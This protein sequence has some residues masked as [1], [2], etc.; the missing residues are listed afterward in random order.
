MDGIADDGLVGAV[1]PVPDSIVTFSRQTSASPPFD[2]DVRKRPRTF[3][4]TRLLPFETESESDRLVHLDH[5]IENIYIAC[6]ANSLS[7]G[8]LLHWTRELRSWLQLKFDMPVST[9]TRL[10]AIYYE[11]ALAQGMTLSASEKF[12]TMFVHL[13]Q[14]RAFVD[15]SQLTLDWRLLFR[16]L[17]RI[18]FPNHW[19]SAIRHHEKDFESLTKMGFIARRFFTPESTLEILEEVLPFYNT[20]R[21]NTAH[22]VVALLD[23]LLPTDVVPEGYSHVY[24]QKWLPSLFHIWELYTRSQHYDLIMMD[25][26]SRLAQGSLHVGHIPFSSTGIFTKEQTALMFT[27]ALR[28]I[29]V[30]V[31]RAGSPYLGAFE[32]HLAVS[33]SDHKRSRSARPIARW[34]ISSLSPDSIIDPDSTLRGLQGLIQCVETFFHP[35]NSGSWTKQ[36]TQLV[37]SLTDFFVLRWNREQSGELDVPPERRLTAE[38]RREFVLTLK[39]VVFM[40]IHSKSSSGAMNSQAALQC[41]AMLEPDI[42]LPTAL[43]QSYPSLQGLVETHRTITSLRT[44]T[45]LSQTVI[46]HKPSRMHVTALLGLALPGIDANDLTKT[47]QSLAFIQSI[48]SYVP[49]ADLSEGIG[50]GLAMEYITNAID[51][52]E[53]DGENAVIQLTDEDE[54]TV[55]KS[56]TATFGEFITSF[57]GRIFSLLENLPDAV[58]SR[59]RAAPEQNAVNMLPAAFSV[60]LGALSD[61]LFDLVLDKYTDFITDHVIPQA[62][63]A[64]ANLMSCLAKAQPERT[65]AKLFKVLEGNIREEI[66]ENHAGTAK[67]LET[68]PKDR[69]LVWYLSMFRKAVW[70]AGDV[71]LKYRTEIVDLIQFLRERCRGAASVHTSNL[72]HH[73]IYALTNV[74]TSD[75]KLLNDSDFK[76]RGYNI[77]DWGRQVDPTDGL[78]VKWHVPDQEQI[79]FAVEVF[80]RHVEL[81]IAELQKLMSEG[82]KAHKDWS[83]EV[84][85][86]LN[87]LRLLISG[88]AVLYDPKK[89]AT[90]EPP[91]KAIESNGD[92]EMKDAEGEEYE[93]MVGRSESFVNGADE[94]GLPLDDDM[95]SDEDDVDGEDGNGDGDGDEESNPIKKLFTYPVGYYFKDT[96]D[97]LYV[98]VHDLHERIGWVLHEVHDYLHAN[99]EDDVHSLKTL[100]SVCRVWFIDVGSER[101]LKLLDTYIRSYL[102]D[103]R[104]YKISG[105]RKC[106]PRYLLTKRAFIYHLQRIKHNNGIRDMSPLDKILLQDLMYDSL[107]RYADTRRQAQHSLDSALRVVSGARVLLVPKLFKELNKAIDTLEY[108]RAKG[109]MYTLN[110]RGLYRFTARDP[111]F[112]VKFALSLL[113][114]TKADKPSI[115]ELA[116]TLLV[117]FVVVSRASPKQ[118]YYSDQFDEYCA[119]IKPKMDIA[120][121]Q[122]AF[123]KKTSKKWEDALKSVQVL[124]QELIQQYKEEQ[125]WRI[126]FLIT[127]LL[128]GGM[129]ILNPVI[130]PDLGELYFKGAIDSHPHLRFLLVQGVLRLIN[131]IFCRALCGNDLKTLVQEDFQD[132]DTIYVTVDRDD[133]DFSEKYLRTLNDV[134]A[135]YYRVDKDRAGWLVW[136]KDFQA[137]LHPGKR[138]MPDFSEEDRLQLQRAGSTIDVE[139]FS[140]YCDLLT[141]EPRSDQDSFRIIYAMFSMMVFMMIYEGYTVISWDQAL[142][143]ISQIY[144]DGEDK[145]HHRAVAELLGGMLANTKST[146]Y[147]QKANTFAIKI[148]ENV[149]DESLTP[150]NLTYWTRFISFL[151][152]M[153]DP[154]SNLPIM[155]KIMSV[156]LDVNSN[157]AFKESSRIS[158]LR[159][160]LSQL[161]WRLDGDQPIVEDFLAHLDH[162]YKGVREEIGRTLGLIPRNS[163]HESFRDVPT[164]IEENHKAG[165]LGIIP[166]QPMQGHTTVLENIFN[167]LAVWRKERQP[168]QETSSYTNGS[169]TVMLWF[170]AWLQQP[171]CTQLMPYFPKMILPELLNLLD[172][173]EDTEVTALAVSIFKHFG[174]VPCPP[175]LLGEIIAGIVEIATTSN[176]WHQRL[177]VLAVVQ[178]FYFRQLFLLSTKD[179]RVLFDC[180]SQLL[181]DPQLEV[182]DTAATTLSGMIRCSPL[183][184][185]NSAIKQLQKRFTDMLLDNPMPGRPSRAESSAQPS[186]SVSPSG[187]ATPNGNSEYNTVVV[188]RHAAVLGL[189][190]LVQAFPYHSPPPNWIPDV[191]TTLANK[192]AND[193]GMVGRSVKTALGE[194][195]KTRQDTWHVDVKVFEKD[196]LEDLEGVLWRSY[197]A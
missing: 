150:E 189:S 140:T 195:K 141:Q 55:L 38:V 50:P 142:E 123:D 174:N 113:K 71:L 66:E 93:K 118:V 173:K 81:S 67:S 136:G 86:Q 164:F 159:H 40:G 84:T 185:R 103:A 122:Q 106:Y 4:Y 126:T 120:E 188:L 156:R 87:Y 182:R 167:Q 191:L 178:V 42:I 90:A 68:V 27:C 97:P 133:P 108:D 157:A 138:L 95:E 155:E 130:P 41:L 45:L 52:L 36:L 127:T 65:F 9:R 8:S 111:R 19:S 54:L 74:Y 6:S 119:Q 175:H 88:A 29:E 131:I 147:C 92:V 109:A 89:I 21:H 46:K 98:K 101:S 1:V 186:T 132:I 169:K 30:P 176:T 85:R 94:E 3:P 183:A 146:D 153:T 161:T 104:I 137:E 194:F 14:K 7:V 26:M 22:Q 47:V 102:V 69:A 18:A 148:F 154:R 51:A 139:W 56:S 107:S 99:Q 181:S 168:L 48:A 158:L 162:S 172:I 73:T 32:A 180:V 5:I 151:T 43:A 13:A 34:I 152:P 49:F 145:N 170:S 166:Y 160:F 179:R 112:F 117:S 149:V 165:S 64:M 134:N 82:A 171:C 193:P 70:T 163:Y 20:S 62:S 114:A 37:Q 105:L 15:R 78:E 72:M 121:T 80:E 35:S 115:H 197:F 79:E 187:I 144:G 23:A 91:P 192:A 83:E 10:T 190:A 60:V 31:G 24:P 128:I 17:K 61:D 44:L 125:H 25:I 76:E 58:N 12:S 39:D 124:E 59:S 116:R 57:M 196:Q 63:D 135:P 33:K 100:A 143:K 28:L 75:G 129:T 77:S 16:E 53:N 184:F 96:S 2:N 11:L 110:M 177:R